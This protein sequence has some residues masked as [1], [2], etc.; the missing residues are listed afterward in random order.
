M[1]KYLPHHHNVEPVSDR[2]TNIISVIILVLLVWLICWMFVD[3]I[4]RTV[5]T[6]EEQR[7][8]RADTVRPKAFRMSSPTPEQM[9]HYHD[10]LRVM[11]V[12][13]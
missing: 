11:E 9:E 3:A 12:M 4:V 10:L 5:E 7:I 6:E 13:R 8:Y 1:G 2:T